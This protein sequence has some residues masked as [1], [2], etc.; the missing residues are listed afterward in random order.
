MIALAIL[1]R[2]SA[3]ALDR[4]VKAADQARAASRKYMDSAQPAI[5]L[6]E[7]N[8]NELTE[9]RIIGPVTVVP[10]GYRR[11]RAVVVRTCREQAIVEFDMP[12][13]ANTY[14]LSEE[15]LEAIPP[16]A[17]QSCD[18]P[19]Y[20]Y[21]DRISDVSGTKAASWSVDYPALERR[22][23]M[24]EHKLNQLTSE[25]DKLQR[26]A[27]NANAALA[28]FN[29]TQSDAIDV[30]RAEVLAIADQIEA[31]GSNQGLVD[32]LRSEYGNV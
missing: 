7:S 4:R 25:L 19:G 29:D 14:D 6:M 22:A 1:D 28:E 15:L 26:N 18:D 21:I 31:D 11:V 12:E 2:K 27:D 13:T 16:N 3:Q 8:D 24:A 23:E 10:A 20:A 17:W 30:A 5:P 32:R 9:P